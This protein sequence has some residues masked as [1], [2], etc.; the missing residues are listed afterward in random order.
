MI[1]LHWYPERR[2]ALEGRLLRRYHERLCEAGISGYAWE[3]CQQDYRIS[4]MMSL[5]IPVWQWQ[6]GIHPCIWWSHLERGFEAF[7]DLGGEEM[8]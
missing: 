1:G 6:R 5:L 3:D 4:M 8:V 2:K 7:K